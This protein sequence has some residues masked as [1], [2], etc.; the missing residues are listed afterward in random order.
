MA[1]F[2]IISVEKVALLTQFLGKVVLKTNRVLQGGLANAF[3]HLIASV[4]DPC[5]AVSQRALLY[6]Q[7][8]PA[9]GLKALQFLHELY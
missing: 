1:T 6:L 8:I 9:A 3:C 5:A 2:L 7:A 4:H